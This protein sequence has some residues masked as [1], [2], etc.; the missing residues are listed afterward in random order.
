MRLTPTLDWIEVALPEQNPALV[1]CLPGRIELIVN[2]SGSRTISAGEGGLV[3]TVE[4]DG[5]TLVRWIT[6]RARWEELD[7]EAK[8]AIDALDLARLLKVY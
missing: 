2:G 6:Q 5:P 4:S 7:L 1:T 8:G 3:A